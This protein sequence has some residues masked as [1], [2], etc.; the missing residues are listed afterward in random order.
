LQGGYEESGEDGWITVEGSD[1]EVEAES[2]GIGGRRPGLEE[3][4]DEADEEQN[5]QE[6]V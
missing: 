3:L 2:E 6:P 4:L 1:D 5:D